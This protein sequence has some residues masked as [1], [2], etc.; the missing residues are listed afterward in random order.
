MV[1]TP[2]LSG[3]KTLAIL[4]NE[5]IIELVGTGQPPVTGCNLLK[6]GSNVQ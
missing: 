1:Y 3:V 6:G 4:A 2:G 5:V